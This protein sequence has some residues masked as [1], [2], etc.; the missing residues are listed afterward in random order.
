MQIDMPLEQLKTY[1]GRNP[2]PADFDH[3]WERALAELDAT[4]P[5]IE[6][7]PADFSAPHAECFDLSFTGVRGAR[8]R[9][10][11]VKPKGGPGTEAMRAPA[12]LPALVH[13]HGYTMSSGDW[14]G[15]LGWAGAGFVSA[16]LDCRGQGGG[17]EDVGGVL[18]NTHNG[19]IIR[20]LDDHEDKL[21]FRDIYLDTVRLA[22]IVMDFADVDPDRVGAT[23]GSQGGGLA[24]ACA[25]LEPRIKRAAPVYPFLSD[26]QR[27]WEMDLA[28]G[29]YQ[30]IQDYFRRFD[31]T[32]AREREVFTRLGYID[33]HHLA[34]RIRANTLMFTGLM[35]EI[36]PPST[37]F[38]AYNAITAPKSMVIYPDF[39][40]EHLPGSQDRIVAHMLEL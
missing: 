19:H 14:S 40:H 21:L 8:V 31:P 33:V 24:L 37:Q 4:P 28:K 34:P 2:K 5:Q 12:G 30:E 32:H 15:Y 26:F 25:S 10:K 36:C 9:A 39:R 20:G 18:G 22:R 17:S 7:T 23:G 27:V 29:A 6:M 3:Y 1:A 16:A 11:V 13:F 38:A 35:D